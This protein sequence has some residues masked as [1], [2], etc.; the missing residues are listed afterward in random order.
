MSD[1]SSEGKESDRE[2]SEEIEEEE[3][4]DTAIL[5]EDDILD[6]EQETPFDV[7]QVNTFWNFWSMTSISDL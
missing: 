6:Q 3:V 2:F 4:L 5:D 7:Q 1:I